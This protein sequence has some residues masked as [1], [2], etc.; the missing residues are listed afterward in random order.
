MM[1]FLRTKASRTR[2]SEILYLAFNALLPLVILLLVNSFDPPYLALVVV[3]LSKWRIFAV[4]PRF[5]WASLKAN[6]VDILVGVSVVGLLFLATSSFPL[7]LLIT[8]LYIGWLLALKPRSNAQGIMA[9]AGIAQFVA[10]IVLFSF[11]AIMPEV[12]IIIGSWFIGYVAARHMV[13]NYEEP[14]VELWSSLWGLF[15]A[16][17][18]WLLFHWTA[19][20]SIGL[21]IQIPQVALIM[22]VLGF[23]VARLY[24]MRKHDTLTP[25]T[26]RGTGLFTIGMLAII[27]IFTPWDATL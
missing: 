14:Y 20:Y 21:P 23:S 9:Q 22:L 16:Q 15:A 17:L 19:M 13:S 3:F 25:G 7:Q 10:F 24:H 6:M 8:A 18:A 27:L 5:W 4:R 1:E 2:A 11:S 26:L 12:A